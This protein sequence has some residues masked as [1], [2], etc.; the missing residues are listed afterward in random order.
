MNARRWLLSLFVAA[1]C[2][3]P[4]H[5]CGGG[6]EPH[7]GFE[8]RRLVAEATRLY[9]GL[10]PLRSSRLGLHEADSL[11]FT[12]GDE[13]II[14]ALEGLA[15]LDERL[16]ALPA[17]GLSPRD[18]DQAR[19]MI[20]WARGERFAFE[21]LAIQRTNPLF[22]V[23]AA[24][25][26]LEGMSSRIEPPRSGEAEAYRARVLAIETLLSNASRS[27][28]N[29]AEMHARF[30]VLRLEGL[31]SRL[32]EISRLAAQRYGTSHDAELARARGALLLFRDRVNRSIAAGARGNII[33]GAE[34]LSKTFLY[35]ELLDID[36]NALIAEAERRIT[37]LAADRAST[38]KRIAFGSGGRLVGGAADS[39]TSV[40]SGPPPG[41]T[42]GATAAD[43][44]ERPEAL[45]ARFI[46]TLWTRRAGGTSFGA[47]RGAKP[48]IHGGANTPLTGRLPKNPHLSLPL[49]DAP[50]VIVET[51]PLSSSACRPRVLMS[52]TAS[53]LDPAE[54]RRALLSAAPALLE[55][56]RILCEA[57]DTV[58][59]V[60]A[61]ETWREGL[62]H[63][64]LADIAER[65][66]KQD[67]ELYARILDE[68]TLRL[69]RTIVV[70]RLHA[71]TLTTERA[72][73]YFSETAGL[74]REDA[75]REALTASTSPAVAWP[76]I[77]IILVERMIDRMAEPGESGAARRKTR[78]LLV[79][80]RGL[81][82]PLIERKIH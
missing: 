78:A 40:K 26:A 23:W 21:T 9:M 24:E 56:D 11:L 37:R 50:D 1:S 72:A 75:E 70:L 4:Q 54:L 43:A 16:S 2:L 5:G 41:E 63:L 77:S 28:R 57:S 55:A 76:G 3:P 42:R 20:H 34:N 73:G 12:F 80:E 66:R 36:P 74:E 6:G 39:R 79:R 32:R 46:D 61:S 82:L 69:A 68:W 44:P 18:I 31:V 81:P 62:A 58:S 15:R 51:A 47:P 60:F 67:P 25:E 52:G 38:A 64:A 22:Y 33:L 65:M 29:P 49:L 59:V 48:A 53:R 17:A 35:D 71:G 7:D 19:V 27:L 13:E 30:A 45:A 8:H 10:H 14:D